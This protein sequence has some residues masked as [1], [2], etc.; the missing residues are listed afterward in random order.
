MDPVLGPVVA[1]SPERKLPYL[2]G[3]G[4]GISELVR[5]RMRADEANK[6]RKL[7]SVPDCNLNHHFCLF[8]DGTQIIIV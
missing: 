1:A 3:Y 6:K 5:E 4:N 7:L 2:S 8:V